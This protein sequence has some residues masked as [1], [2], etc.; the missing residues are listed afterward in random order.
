MRTRNEEPIGEDH[1]GRHEEPAHSSR[2]KPEPRGSKDR[3]MVTAPAATDDTKE[4]PDPSVRG[5]APLVRRDGR[6]NAPVGDRRLTVPAP[7]GG[8]TIVAQKGAVLNV[9]LEMVVS[10]NGGQRG[11]KTSKLLLGAPSIDLQHDVV[12][13]EEDEP[14]TPPTESVPPVRTRKAGKHR[15]P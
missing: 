2:Q 9:K 10:A 13:E 3:V 7:H 6:P 1:E 15:A 8:V 12:T 14:T 4:V 5:P 11:S